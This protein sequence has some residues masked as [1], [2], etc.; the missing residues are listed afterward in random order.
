[1]DLYNIDDLIVNI[2][3]KYSLSIALAK[4][5]RELGIYLTA[6]KNMERVNIVPP[7]IDTKDMEDPLEIAM[8]ELREGKIS[9]V[10]EKDGIK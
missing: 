9:F 2:D 7:L 10:R 3:S 4:R 5:A 6:K 1:M 8:Q